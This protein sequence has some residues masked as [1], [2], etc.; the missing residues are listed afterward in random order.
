MLMSVLLIQMT[1][2][3]QNIRLFGFHG[4]SWA[5]QS[6]GSTVEAGLIRSP[7]S[8]AACMYRTKQSYC[9]LLHFVR[10]RSMSCTVQDG[11]TVGRQLLTGL[12]PTFARLLMV[13]GRD[14]VVHSP[15]KKKIL[16]GGTL[17]KII[18]LIWFD[19]MWC[20]VTPQEAMRHAYERINRGWSNQR[21]VWSKTK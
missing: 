9:C 19:L 5:D 14:T 8:K 3:E 21:S 18:F 7:A 4:W 16:Y 20:D 1:K 12:S 15:Q 13:T 10:Q 17:H 2:S 11:T 6:L